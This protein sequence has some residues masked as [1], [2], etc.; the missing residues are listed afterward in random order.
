MLNSE[1]T[2]SWILLKSHDWRSNPVEADASGKPYTMKL[3]LR[4]S[5]SMYSS[6]ALRISGDAWEAVWACSL[7]DE[8]VVIYCTRIARRP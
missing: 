2:S 4:L 5:R 1:L 7:K 3:D 8:M 6:M